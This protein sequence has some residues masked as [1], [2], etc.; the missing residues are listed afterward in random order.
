MASMSLQGYL[1][2]FHQGTDQFAVKSRPQ[3]AFVCR[4]APQ[5]VKEPC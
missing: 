1:F 5:A 2:G 3:K 4:P